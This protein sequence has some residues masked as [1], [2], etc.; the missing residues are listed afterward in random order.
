MPQVF[1]P[2]MNTIARVSIFGA[3]FVI[4]GSLLLGGAIVRSPYV[5]DVGVI[6][7][8]PV[9][10]SH[11]HH[12]G[13]IG[14][15]CVYCHRT[16]ETEATAGMPE[17]KVCLD[18]HSQLWSDSPM[19][20]PVRDSLR[21]G[22]P[23]VWTRVHDLPDYVFFHHGAHVSQGIACSACHGDVSEMPLMHRTHTLH[24]EWCLDCHRHPE[25]AI[26]EATADSSGAQIGKMATEG[27]KPSDATGLTNCSRCHH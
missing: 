17:T 12:V 10:F 5:T 8:Q 25:V 13:D 9:P 26:E 15:D 21:S 14:I 18:C 1:H 22:R 6:R 23:L 4:A 3:V 2:S 19:L 7:N 16:V 24:M 27:R 20:Q 11:Q